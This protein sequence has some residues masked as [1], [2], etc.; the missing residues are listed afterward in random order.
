ME[1]VVLALDLREDLEEALAIEAMIVASDQVV[2]DLVHPA[3]NRHPSV[4]SNTNHV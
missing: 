2:F 1:A 3:I 4:N